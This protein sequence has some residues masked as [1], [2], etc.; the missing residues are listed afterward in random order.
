MGKEA[1]MDTVKDE[2]RKL[3]DSMPDHATW[4]DVM[5]EFYVKKKL[6]Q[7]L[8][9]AAEGDVISHEEVKEQLFSKS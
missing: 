5:Y 1:P 9:E 2:A 6:E 4:D 7:A 3:I 8:K